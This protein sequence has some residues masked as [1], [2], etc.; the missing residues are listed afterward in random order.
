MRLI[1]KVIKP[2]IKTLKRIK[3]TF[4]DRYEYL[5]LD[6]NERLLPFNDVVFQE[7]LSALK[8]VELSG[9]PELGN[10]YRKLANYLEVS[11]EQIMLASGSD[12]AIKSIFDACIGIGDNIILHAPCYAMYRIYAEMFGAEPRM[13][14]IQDNWTV[15]HESMLK[16]V[17]KKTKFVA[18]ENPNGFIGSQP[19]FKIIEKCA[20]ELL[21]KSTLLVIDE[22]YYY[23]ENTTSQTIKLIEKYPNVIISQTFSKGHGLAGARIGYIIGNTEMIEHISRVRPMHEI[24]GLTA[25]ATDWILKNPKLLK[26]YQIEISNSKIYLKKR[27]D[28]INIKYRDTHANFMLLYLPDK[29]KTKDI[30]NKLRRYHNILIRRPF[31]ELQM[32]GWSRVCIGSVSDSQRFISALNDILD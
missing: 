2:E 17:N 16:Q 26:E 24:S 5:R 25:I 21:D 23:I 14:P 9:Y 8:Q 1:D 13:V 29:G 15:N 27:L 12:L 31:E 11:E 28:K 22:A 18:L 10:I 32:K 30:T 19:Q 20:E 3:D 7:F 4:N 6:K